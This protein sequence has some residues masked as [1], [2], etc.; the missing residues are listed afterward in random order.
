MIKESGL[1]IYPFGEFTCSIGGMVLMI[2]GL[3]EAAQKAVDMA[4]EQPKKS[5]Y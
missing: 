4:K 1:D 2:D 5:N 3:D